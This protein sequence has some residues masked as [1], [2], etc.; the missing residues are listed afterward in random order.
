MSRKFSQLLPGHRPNSDNA[1]LTRD[2]HL[3]TAGT[4]AEPQNPP[5]L[6]TE[7]SLQPPGEIPSFDGA[8][9]TSGDQLAAI[10]RKT[11]AG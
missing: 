6:A 9:L 8:I 3:L 11:E 10:G 5:Q 2:R 4:E 7:L 1:I